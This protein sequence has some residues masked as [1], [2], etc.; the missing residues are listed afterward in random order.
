MPP[1]SGTYVFDLE[2][3]ECVGARVTEETV[4]GHNAA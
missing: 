4:G 1:T 2:V 3:L